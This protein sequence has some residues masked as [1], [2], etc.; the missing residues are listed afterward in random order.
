MLREAISRRLFNN[1][2]IISMYNAMS[3][4]Y[5]FFFFVLTILI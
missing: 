4:W 1:I 3:S 2:F 5:F